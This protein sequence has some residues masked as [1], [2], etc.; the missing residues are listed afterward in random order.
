[1]KNSDIKD[2]LDVKYLHF[3]NI[4][5]IEKDPISI[6]HQFTT[7]TDIE[8][9]GFL[10]ATLAWGQRPVIL[11]KANQL[12]GLMDHSPTEFIRG[13]KKADLK[14][15]RNFKHRTFNEVDC[16]AFL[17]ALQHIFM[18][19][20]CLED[21]FC[22]KNNYENLDLNVLISRF[23]TRFFQIE[24]EYRSEKHLSDPLTGSAV[25]RINMFL[26][27]MVRK[28]SYGVDFG[29]WN[30]IKMSQLMLPLDVHS[31]RVARALG[32]L[33]RRQDDW[34]AVKEVTM[35]LQKFDPE[36]PVKYDFALFG[37]GAEN[38]F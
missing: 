3:N 8:I 11:S 28:D 27:W 19:F 6:P 26:R 4:G 22:G 12:L 33:K 20:E 25:K 30:K 16:I 1:M 21:A 14:K 38:D 17:M 7:K 34:T 13:F 18:E 37:M 23:R 9:I 36:D 10:T 32:L 2:L 5:F 24:H 35:K 29:I 31:G 15:F